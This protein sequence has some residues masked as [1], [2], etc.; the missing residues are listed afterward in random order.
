MWHVHDKLHDYMCSLVP[1]RIC[2]K[3]KMFFRV[4][5]A[6]ITSEHDMHLLG[7]FA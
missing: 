4:Y 5:L 2:L 1:V 3:F 7:W 6:P